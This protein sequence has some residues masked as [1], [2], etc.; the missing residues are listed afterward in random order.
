MA[1]KELLNHRALL[2]Y[3][4]ETPAVATVDENGTVKAVGTG[5][6]RIYVQTVNGIWQT[7]EVT[8]K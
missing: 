6:C 4:S 5:W 7:V 2:R 3:R 1:G 8:V